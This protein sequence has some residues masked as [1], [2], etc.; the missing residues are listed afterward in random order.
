MLMHTHDRCIDH[1]RG[2]VSGGQRFQYLVPDAASDPTRT[3]AG[4]E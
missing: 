4:A 3:S 1:L 2:I